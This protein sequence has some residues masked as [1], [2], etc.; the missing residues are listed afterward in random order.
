[1]TSAVASPTSPIPQRIATDGQGD[2][3][4]K[5]LVERLRQTVPAAVPITDTGESRVTDRGGAGASASYRAGVLVQPEQRFYAALSAE[6]MDP[7]TTS[8][9]ATCAPWM[10]A[11]STR[12]IGDATA[13]ITGDNVSQ[14]VL[15]DVYRSDHG[16]PLRVRATR[17]VTRDT[18]LFWQG[19]TPAPQIPVSADALVALATSLLT[20]PV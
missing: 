14:T 7:P 4:A 11:C 9:E 2:E 12:E 16:V 3:R 1:M 6:V 19:G 10:Y 5:R 15:V 8:G 17:S 20:N 13:V 18:S